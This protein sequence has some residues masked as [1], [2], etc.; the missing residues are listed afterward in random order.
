VA[1]RAQSAGRLDAQQA[2][3]ESWHYL[4]EAALAYL[5]L[6]RH[7]TTESLRR[8]LAL[9]DSL[10]IDCNFDRLETAMLLAASGRDREAY[11][12]LVAVWPEVSYA[13]RVSEG[14]WILERAR[15]AERLGARKTA[16]DAYRWV[17]EIWRNADPELQPYVVDARTG[18]ARMA[19]QPIK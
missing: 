8:F 14:L 19:G 3:R 13:P 5:A 12:S 18:L 15:L 10:C 6:A 9:P 4:A 2:R 1:R 11:A 16:A 17:A 7:D